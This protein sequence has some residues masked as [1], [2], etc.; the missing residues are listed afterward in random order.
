MKDQSN[1]PTVLNT[2]KR[3][4]FYYNIHYDYFNVITELKDYYVFITELR[5]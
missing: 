1:T 5:I 3:R 4:I 2:L